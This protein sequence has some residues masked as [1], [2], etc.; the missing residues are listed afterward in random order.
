[1][2]RG[3][4]GSLPLHRVT[5]SFTTPRR[6]NPAH[7]ESAMPPVTRRTFLAP[8]GL[9]ALAAGAVGSPLAGARPARAAARVGE[10][11]QP[12]TAPA[13]TGGVVSLDAHHGKLSVLEWT[14]HDC[15]YVRK[16]YESGNMQAL[17]KETTGQGIVWLTIISSAPG[18]QGHVS[19]AEANALTTKR[20]A[21]PPAVLLDPQG[22]V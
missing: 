16:H 14:N 5:L 13:S 11:A 22:T 3:R 4:C 1:M 21:S 20:G 10:L 6:F 9:P 2:T 7:K 17:Q 12:F 8:A 15:P 18:E 19:P